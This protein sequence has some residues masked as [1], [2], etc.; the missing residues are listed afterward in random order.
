[1]VD[2]EHLPV[3]SEPVAED[4]APGEDGAHLLAERRGD[5]DTGV[6]HDR[7][8]ARVAHVPE[9]HGQRPL[10]RPPQETPLAGEPGRRHRLLASLS[11]ETGNQT[12]DLLLDLHQLPQRRLLRR[13]LALQA[14]EHRLLAP[15]AVAQ[16][17]TNRHSRADIEPQEFVEFS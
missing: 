3:A 8:E 5:V 14:R 1:M 2:H 15:P 4:D 11:L 16:L 6:R 7:V 10:R 13:P 12:L 9:R 17:V